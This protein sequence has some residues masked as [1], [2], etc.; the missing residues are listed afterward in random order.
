MSTLRR[1]DLLFLFLF[2]VL[3]FMFIVVTRYHE[4][5]ESNTP[6]CQYS[7][8]NTVFISFG[9]LQQRTCH[10]FPC[11]TALCGDP[12]HCQPIRLNLLPVIGIIRIVLLLHS[13]SVESPRG[14][15]K[16]LPWCGVVKPIN[17]P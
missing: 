17:H 3:Y 12:Q 9:Y 4:C 6:S 5:F 14:L 10:A 13:Q 16:L 2:L 8:L 15:T 7:L 1:H 11:I